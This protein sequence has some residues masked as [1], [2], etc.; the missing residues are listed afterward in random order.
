MKRPPFPLVWDN[1]MRSSFVSCPQKFWW[2]YGEHFKP[3]GTVSTDLHAGQA[4]AKGLE[5]SRELFY[6]GHAKAKE[7][8][9]EGLRA[10]IQAYGDHNPQ[11]TKENKSLPRLMDAFGYYWKAFP[12]EQDPVQPYR[13]KDGSPMVEFSFALPIDPE[14]LRHPE[15]DEPI[16]Y[17]GRADMVATYGG[18]L[19]IYDDKTTSQLGEKWGAQWLR[20]GQ[21]TGYS[22]AARAYNIPVTQV[23]IRGI[24]ILKT[25]V[26]HAQ[27]ITLRTPAHI[28][29]WHVQLIR[30]IQ[31]AIACW[32]EGYWDLNLSDTC[33]AYG[34]CM[35]MQPCFSNNPSP[36]LESNFERRVWDPLKREE[37]VIPIQ[38][39]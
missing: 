10:L 18:A 12:F 2:E 30:D 19:S 32:K 9:A 29:E 22:W 14:L 27:V 6:G 15:T 39:V 31:R 13:K 17:S 11:H 4:W 21:F 25:S 8:Q 35:F 23:V 34:G 5:V 36:W 38:P 16:I 26:N 28:L 3:R 24:A 33:S 20:R 1:T 37:L 7:A